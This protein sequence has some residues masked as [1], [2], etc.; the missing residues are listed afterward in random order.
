[1]ARSFLVA[2]ALTRPIHFARNELCPERGAAHAGTQQICTGAGGWQRVAFHFRVAAAQFQT[3]VLSARRL[4]RPRLHLSSGAELSRDP[5][6]VPGTLPTGRSARHR[7]ALVDSWTR[8]DPG[9]LRGLQSVPAALPGQRRSD[10]R[11]SVV[12]TGVSSLSEL[13]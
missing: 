3:A 9:A 7:I 13:Y 2:G 10:R 1:M 12:S 8:Q 11:S 4:A 5:V 6:L